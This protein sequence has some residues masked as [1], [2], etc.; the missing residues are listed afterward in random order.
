M[1][2]KTISCDWVKHAVL[3][4]K[5]ERIEAYFGGH[6]YAPHRHDTYAIGLTLAGV[7]SFK[8]RRTQ[9]HSLPGT[10]MV[11]HPDEIHDG[12]AGT[13]AGFHYRMTYI[14]PSL[15]QRIL[16]GKPLPFIED[17]LSND[18]RL[19]TAVAPLLQDMRAE[20][21]PMQEE[22][23]LYDL[24]HALVTVAGQKRIRCRP[25]FIA[26]ERA[27]AYINESLDQ[28]ISLD[29]MADASGLDRWT[30]CRDFRVLYGTSPYRYLT[31]RRLDLVRRLMLSGQ[32]IAESALMAGFFDQSHMARQFTPT[33]GV[34]PARWLKRIR[35]SR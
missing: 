5:I 8:Y 15:I 21:D 20:I 11:L 14:E 24:A 26:V 13:E 35:H 33:Y 3:A 16:G 6:G 7:Q 25:D 1:I 9:R 27:R 31:M 17:G 23:A 2:K 4:G 29:M 19:R 12:E 18:L 32:S 28:T 30:L 10:I 34:S 22:D